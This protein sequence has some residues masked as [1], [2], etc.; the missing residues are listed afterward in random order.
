MTTRVTLEKA[1][2][3]IAGPGRWVKDWQDKRS[4]GEMAYC[5]VGAV[6]TVAGLNAT[7]HLGMLGNLTDDNAEVARACCALGATIGV[8]GPLGVV[9]YNDNHN[10][11]CVLGMFDAAIENEK[12]KEAAS[13]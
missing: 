2:A 12:K 10:Q 9:K 11:E 3:L 6:R 8:T 13:S 4:D 7:P 1:R 5:A